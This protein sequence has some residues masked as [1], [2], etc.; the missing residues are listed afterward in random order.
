MADLTT[1]FNF[2]GNLEN[3][4]LTYFS[5]NISTPAVQF[6]TPLGT[7]ELEVPRIEIEVQSNGSIDNL[8]Y[9]PNAGG[10]KQEYLDYNIDLLINIVTD[11]NTNTQAQHRSIR[12]QIRSL[13]TRN[14]AF[15]TGLNYYAIRYLRNV[16]TGY[17]VNGDFNQSILGYMMIVSIKPG[18]WPV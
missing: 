8:Q 12:N 11:N 14:G 3:H 18:E 6:V 13:L 10:D 5:N 1:L 4:F 9:A 7:A 15:N 17:E 16:Q 2:E